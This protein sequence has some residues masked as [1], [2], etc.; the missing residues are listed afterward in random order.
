MP[1]ESVPN[2]AK[3]PQDHKKKTPAQAEAEGAGVTV[4]WEGESFELPATVDDWDLDALEAFEVGQVVTGIRH[5]IGNDRYDEVRRNL[6]K[7]LGRKLKV[8]DL[9]PLGDEI[10]RIYGF[11]QAGN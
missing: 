10:A 3:Q 2:N 1:F 5:L 8:G 11:G 6:T 9:K 7:R 4:E